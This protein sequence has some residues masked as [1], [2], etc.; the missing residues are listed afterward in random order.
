VL[1]GPGGVLTVSTAHDEAAVASAIAGLSAA[2]GK[3]AE[4]QRTHA[5]SGSVD[6]LPR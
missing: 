5:S 1:I 3:I 4:F 6:A 2:L